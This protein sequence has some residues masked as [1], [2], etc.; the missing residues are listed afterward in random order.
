MIF[1]GFVYDN[2]KGK[3]KLIDSEAYPV[4]ACDYIIKNIDIDNAR[5]YNDYDFGSYM[6]YRNI[7]VFIDSR[8]DLY[9]SK[10][11]KKEDDIFYDYMQVFSMTKYYKEIFDKYGITHLIIYK[12]SNLNINIEGS[13]DKRYEKIYE[14]KKFVIYK[15]NQDSQNT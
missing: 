3:Y 1:S 8:A 6:I 2:I 12:S 7:P 15:Y 5:F 13:N 10:F 11:S 14:D 4:N 9:D